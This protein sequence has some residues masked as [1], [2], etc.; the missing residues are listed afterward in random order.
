MRAL[1]SFPLVTFHDALISINGN[2]ARAGVG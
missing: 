1:S 2:K